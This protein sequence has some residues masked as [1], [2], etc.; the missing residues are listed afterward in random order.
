MSIFS[1]NIQVNLN[2]ISQQDIQTVNNI[3]EVFKAYTHISYDDIED[4]RVRDLVF[5][6][7]MRLIS[8]AR[9]EV[10]KMMRDEKGINAE[11]H[12]RWINDFHLF[13]NLFAWTYN[14]INASAQMT[15]FILFP[16]QLKYHEDTERYLRTIVTKGRGLGFTWVKAVKSVWRLYRPEDYKGKM[17]SRVETD[18]DNVGDRDQTTFGKMRFIMEKLP[19][20]D[21]LDERDKELHIYYKNN[22]FIGMSSHPDAARNSRATEF[23]VEESGVIENFTL[24]M[25]AI[26]SV[27]TEIR[28]GGSVKGTSNGF[29]DYWKKKDNSYFHI[30]WNYLLHPLYNC[31]SWLKAE[32][33]KYGEDVAGFNQEVLVDWFSSV[34][35]KILHT[36]T[37]SHQRDISYIHNTAKTNSN[38]IKGVS[39]DVGFGSSNT[40]LWFFYY[41]KLSDVF[42][43][44]DYVEL[45]RSSVKEIYEE[46]LQRGFIW[47]TFHCVDSAAKNTIAT[48][49][50]VLS[51]MTKEGLNPFPID[52][53]DIRGSV[54]IANN[55]IGEGKV[56]FHNSKAVDIGF[57]KLS[58]Y[59]FTEQFKNYKQKKDENSDAGDSFR[60]MFGIIPLYKNQLKTIQRPTPQQVQSL[61]NGKIFNRRKNYV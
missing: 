5:Q 24:I 30:F 3:E 17:L 61:T 54:I 14:P 21:G 8:Y 49:E 13:A 41:D 35:N 42:W 1:N 23:Q 2:K 32:K 51:L 40:A 55:Y 27:A 36:L 57:D 48:G 45:N 6:E 10:F 38:L 22:S 28:I 29:Y 34:S 4:Y 46:C 52:N 18:V 47:D 53:K 31:E 15:P 9:I 50:T 12:N 37:L 44:V 7:L 11:I 26:I 43:V 60:Y 19:F 58:K 59:V 25:R 39:V 56:T 16:Y 20:F 33:A